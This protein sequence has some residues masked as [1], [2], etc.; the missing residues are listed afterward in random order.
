MDVWNFML[1]LSPDNTVHNCLL[2]GRVSC[3][4]FICKII[5]ILVRWYRRW[6]FFKRILLNIF[7]A[8]ELQ[9]SMIETME[10]VEMEKQRHH[11]TRMEALAR[12]ARL[13]VYRCV[14]LCH[15]PPLP[16]L[17]HTLQIVQ[18]TE[19]LTV[20]VE[21]SCPLVTSLSNALTEGF[22]RSQTQSLQ[23]CLP[24]NNG[25]WKFK[26]VF[27]FV[28]WFFRLKKQWICWQLSSVVTTDVGS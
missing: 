14:W 10:A 7:Q 8:S 23:N 9:T 1:I 6:W 3:S 15:P 25:I 13:E 4:V 16:F 2:Q 24:G 27:F 5:S 18:Y 20:V 12:L 21:N 19:P 28:H 22:R 17:C 11:S 26:Y